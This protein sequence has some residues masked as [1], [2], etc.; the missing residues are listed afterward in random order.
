MLYLLIGHHHCVTTRSCARRPTAFHYAVAWALNGSLVVGKINASSAWRPLMLISTCLL[1]AQIRP[2][3]MY[4]NLYVCLPR[5]NPRVCTNTGNVP[6][7]NLEG[8]LLNQL[9]HLWLRGSKVLKVGRASW[10]NKKVFY[11]KLCVFIPLKLYSPV[12]LINEKT[13][14]GRFS[15]LIFPWQK[16]YE[17]NV[18]S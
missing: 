5:V 13:M 7:L 2:G 16:S 17:E 18:L 1:S 4:S 10:Q 8:K 3:I 14:L 6:G 11:I 9:T 15:P 12:T